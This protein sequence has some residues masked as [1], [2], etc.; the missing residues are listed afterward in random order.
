M[1]ANSSPPSRAVRSPSLKRALQPLR[2]HPQQAIAGGMAEGV[3][4]VLELIQVEKANREPLLLALAQ[5]DRGGELV[6]EIRAI[7][8][9]GE[10]VVMSEIGDLG[11][12][13]LS[14][15]DVDDRHQ[16]AGAAVVGDLPAESEDFDF[17]A[18]AANVSPAS[19]G[20]IGLA[21]LQ[22][23]ASLD[24]PLVRVANFVRRHAEEAI[25]RIAVMR[26]R[27]VVHRQEA[28]GRD[29]DDPHRHRIGVEQQPVG[30]LPQF[31][32]GDVR[33]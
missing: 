9:L 26:D 13:P 18:V 20:S 4:D 33:Q 8:Q 14:L 25:A 21:G 23:R 19:I 17:A 31:Q 24:V 10:R 1:A 27:R 15:G 6:A 2:D 30:F 5:I 7:A 12:G 3:V 22:E 11:L 29:V 16:F 28:L 32:L